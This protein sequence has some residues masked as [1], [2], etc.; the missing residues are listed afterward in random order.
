MAV[1]PVA[2]MHISISG[3]VAYSGSYFG[4]RSS[5]PFMTSVYCYGSPSRILDCRYSAITVS[6]NQVSDAGVV[7]IGKLIESINNILLSLC[8]QEKYKGQS[9]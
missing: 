5:P 7:C 2:T 9:T 8:N 6:C 4:T 1:V 3:A